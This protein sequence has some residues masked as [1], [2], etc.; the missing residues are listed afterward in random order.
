M[1][2]GIVT[3]APVC[4]EAAWV[5]VQDSNQQVHSMS[6]HS[7]TTASTDLLLLAVP[8]RFS[9]H[10]AQASGQSVTPFGLENENRILAGVNALGLTSEYTSYWRFKSIVEDHSASTA[11]I[12]MVCI[13]QPD[14][15]GKMGSVVS[16]CY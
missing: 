6:C 10:C 5:A 12:V 3:K 8:Q 15:H 2:L 1:P 7:P 13:R 16:H 4:S 14:R 9:C 11:R